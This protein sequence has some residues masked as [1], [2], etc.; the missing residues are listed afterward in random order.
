MTEA[1]KKTFTHPRQATEFL[2]GLGFQKDGYG[3]HKLETVNGREFQWEAL[4]G[5]IP[6]TFAVV[7]EIFDANEYA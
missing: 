3:W 5:A 6:D 4:V 2:T 1:C 7:V